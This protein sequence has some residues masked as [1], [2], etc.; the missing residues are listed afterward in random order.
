MLKILLIDEKSHKNVLIYDISYKNLI[1]PKSFQIRFSKIDGFIRI[2]DGTRYLTLFD[3]EN[4]DAIYSRIRSY[5]S[6]KWYHCMK[7]NIFV[8]M[9]NVNI[10]FS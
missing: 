5:Q 4:Y 9:L 6:K 8:K 10:I 7:N 2:Y 3:S 1:G